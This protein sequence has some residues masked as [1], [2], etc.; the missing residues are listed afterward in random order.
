MTKKDTVLP[1]VYELVGEI[2]QERVVVENDKCYSRYMY[3]LLHE[4]GAFFNDEMRRPD[5]K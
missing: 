5:V 3:R 2:T 1:Q 4:K